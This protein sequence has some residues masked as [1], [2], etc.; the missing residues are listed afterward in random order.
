MSNHLK[1]IHLCKYKDF[2]EDQ[3]KANEKSKANP[4]KQKNKHVFVAKSQKKITDFRAVPPT[5][6]LAV[7]LAVNKGLP[8]STFDDSSMR[9]LILFAKIGGKD[10]SLTVINSSNVKNAVGSQAS[11]KR[12]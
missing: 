2:K 10:N 7:E 1:C 4:F 5:M 11:A 3:R 6:K 12:S 9:K 8:F